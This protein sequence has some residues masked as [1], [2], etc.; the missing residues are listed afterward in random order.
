[1]GVLAHLVERDVRNVKVRGSYL[2]C[3]TND[4]AKPNESPILHEN[5]EKESGTDNEL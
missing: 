2:R 4:M 3:A 5:K 1:M